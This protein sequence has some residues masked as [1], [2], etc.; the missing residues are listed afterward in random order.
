MSIYT[1]AVVKNAGET[2]CEIVMICCILVSAGL[3]PSRSG[4]LP[5]SRFLTFLRQ[6]WIPENRGFEQMLISKTVLQ[7]LKGFI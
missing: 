4:T 1:K 3:G 5:Y 7:T 6:R 2:A